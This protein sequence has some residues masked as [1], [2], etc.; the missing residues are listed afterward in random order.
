[1]IHIAEKNKCCGCHACYN[2]CPKHC[3]TM[4]ED[5]EG[6]LYPSISRE[7]CIECGICEKVCP[8]LDEE[9]RPI[10]IG[11]YAAQSKDGDLLFN[12]SSGGIFSVLALNVIE[13]GGVVFGAAFSLDYKEVYHIAID[14]S[15][16][17]AK[18]RTSKYVQSRIG[19][20]Y[21]AVRNLLDDGKE[22]LFSGV[23]CQISGLKKYLKK[24]YEN[25][26]CI[27]V[28]CHGV[29]SPELWKRY[30][31]NLEQTYQGI[32]TDVNF[33]QKKHDWKNFGTSKVSDGTE[34]YA[35]K[36][37]DSYMQMF[38][39]N[40][41]LRPSC[42]S[43]QTKLVGSNAD[44]TLGD[45]WGI[46]NVVPN[47]ND[48]RGTS[49]V[50]INSAKGHRLFQESIAGLET[51]KVAYD[52]VKEYNSPIYKSVVKPKERDLFF[53]DMNKLTFAELVTK[54]CAPKQKSLKQKLAGTKLWEKTRRIV[55]GGGLSDRFDYGIYIKVKR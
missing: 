11:A 18:L 25:L 12:S 53:A 13:K 48:G 16:E 29:P 30:L 7:S 4:K 42:Y 23:P 8:V 33:R 45:F 6:F 35:S 39:R 47:M 17:L 41:S 10:P 46:E 38:L 1:M 20:S 19:E 22:V 55:R 34:I 54:Y 36:N 3:I 9:I 21:Q 43:C 32:I 49:A 15:T 24:E 26:T 28:I 31:I 27:D 14:N 52:D 37:T 5:E 40:Y 50:V 2:S 51:K 44:I